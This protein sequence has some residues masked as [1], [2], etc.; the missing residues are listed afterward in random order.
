MPE[1]LDALAKEK[2][3]LRRARG[4]QY[5]ETWLRFILMHVAGGLSHQHTVARASEFGLPKVSAV[6][7]FKRLRKAPPWL[8]GLSAS[9]LEEH[10]GVGRV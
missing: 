4:I 10:N 9:L 6:A 3:F 8:Q 5:S 2:K 7:L 1:G